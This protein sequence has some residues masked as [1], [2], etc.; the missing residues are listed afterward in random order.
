MNIEEETFTERE[1]LIA[2]IAFTRGHAAALDGVSKALR[3]T[4]AAA[5]D[6]QGPYIRAVLNGFADSLD[7]VIEKNKARTVDAAQGAVS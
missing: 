2:S 6:A 4:G 5:D 7:A 1:K 3:S